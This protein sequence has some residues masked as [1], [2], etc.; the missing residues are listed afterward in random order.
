M[1]RSWTPLSRWELRRPVLFTSPG[2]ISQMG[3]ASTTSFG[4]CTIATCTTRPSQTSLL[5]TS[6]GEV[7]KAGGG[8]CGYQFQSLQEVWDLVQ[9]NKVRQLRQ[10]VDPYER[11]PKHPLPEEEKK[12]SAKK[13]FRA[14]PD[15]IKV[16]V[17]AYPITYW[18]VGG[19]TAAELA[20]TDYCQQGPFLSVRK[21]DNRGAAHFKP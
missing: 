18:V 19:W 13:D 7:S 21:F 6:L 1:L 14:T 5:N 17:A 8:S 9:R 2:G 15:S 11:I 4:Q 3:T 16:P 12:R 10:Q 20:D